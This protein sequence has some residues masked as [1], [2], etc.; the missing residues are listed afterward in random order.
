MK[1]NNKTM[2]AVLYVVG[3]ILSMFGGM[4]FSVFMFFSGTF[5]P[6]MHVARYTLYALMLVIVILGA[7][8]FNEGTNYLKRRRR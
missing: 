2:R 6:N 5:L 7:W 3:G 4:L 8:F 1:K